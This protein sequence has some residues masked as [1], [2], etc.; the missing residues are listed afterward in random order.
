MALTATAT[1][2]SRIRI[3]HSLRMNDPFLIYVSP[4]KKNI[5]YTVRPK[6]VLED[7]ISA[8]SCTLQ[9]LRTSMP[10]TIIFCR[11]Y[12]ECAQIYSLFQQCLKA[13]FTD[14]PNAPNL[15]KYRLID[16]YTKCTEPSIKEDIVAA[17]SNAAEKLRIIVATV[18]F[19]MGLDCP[20]VRQIFHW[21]AS[22]DID[23]Y[24]QETGRCGRDGYAS[25]AVLFYSSKDDKITSPQM[26]D[27]CKNK[28]LCRRKVLFKDFEESDTLEMP[29]S[30]CMCCDICKL[31]CACE[32]CKNSLD[33][34]SYSFTHCTNE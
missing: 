12:V 20:D 24:I 13:N 6:P 8:L 1:H 26:I 23:S 17:F 3:I 4:H 16:M 2:M 30:F 9:N 15:V 11:R 7:F 10:R 18:A 27:Y 19:G 34:V 5:V 14:P 33:L 28:T 22:H 32:N 21:G 25:N 31:K 29:C